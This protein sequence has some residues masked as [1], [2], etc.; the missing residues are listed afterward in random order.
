[1]F[2]RHCTLSVLPGK[3]VAGIATC[4]FPVKK[5]R[6]ATGGTFFAL[7]TN[8]WRASFWCARI[9]RERKGIGCCELLCYRRTLRLETRGLVPI[10]ASLCTVRPASSR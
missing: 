3:D 7:M 9:A 2:P 1:M 6:C 5:K 4:A 10:F 8:R